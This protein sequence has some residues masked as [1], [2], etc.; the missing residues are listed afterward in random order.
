MG[1]VTKESSITSDTTYSSAAPNSYSSVK[2]YFSS[3]STFLLSQLKA[4]GDLVLYEYALAALI[5]MKGASTCMMLSA[6]VLG[7]RLLDKVLELFFYWCSREL[8]I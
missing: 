4:S 5:S 2:M 7:G 8:C 6:S 3:A 1:N